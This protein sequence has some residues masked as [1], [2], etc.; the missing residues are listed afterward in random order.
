MLTVT[1]AFKTA[2]QQPVKR[3]LGYLVLPDG[4]QVVGDNNGDLQKYSIDAT[5]DLLKTAMGHFTSTLIGQHDTVKGSMVDAYYGVYHD[6][7]YEYILKGKF[8]ITDA[9]YNKD[10]GTTDL[11]GYDNM[12]RFQQPYTSV[13]DFPVTL[14]EY[15]QAVCSGAGVQL[16]NTSIYNGSLSIPLD[17]YTDIQDTTFRDV[18]ED[19]CET[20]GTNARILPNGNLFLSTIQETGETLTYDNLKKPVS[21]QDM[22]GGINSVVLSR[23]PQNE[24]EYWRDEDDISTPTTRN[25]LDLTKFQVTYSTEDA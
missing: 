24:N 18:L 15:L 11:E 25:I 5:G 19:I 21:F 16:E 22:Y 4:T 10:S 17:Y 23:Q 8:N 20:T 14:F 12:L 9:K 6:G 1:P 13:S 3:V 7:D 2:L